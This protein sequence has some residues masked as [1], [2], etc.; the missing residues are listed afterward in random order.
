MGKVSG[1]VT[2]HNLLGIQPSWCFTMFNE[3]WLGGMCSI[4]LPSVNSCFVASSTLLNESVLW[5]ITITNLS[6]SC[7]T[8]SVI[9]LGV[10]DRVMNAGVTAGCADH[11]D[12]LLCYRK[13]DM[14][15]HP[16][17]AWKNSRAS[18]LNGP[19]FDARV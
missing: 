17:N 6:I 19:S 3:A 9:S 2:I 1:L 5:Y 11:G 13:L 18:H 8:P 14:V 4:V 12:F 10:E 16:L 7:S 15:S